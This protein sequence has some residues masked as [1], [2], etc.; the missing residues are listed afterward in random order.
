MGGI[1]TPFRKALLA[2]TKSFSTADPAPIQFATAAETRSSFARGQIAIVGYS[3]GFWA[4]DPV[5]DLQMF[6]TPGLHPELNFITSDRPLQ[7]MLG[8]LDGVS[9]EQ[10][11]ERLKS[12]NRYL[13]EGALASVVSHARLF[14]LARDPAIL[15][16]PIFALSSPAPWQIFNYR[17]NL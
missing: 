7:A 5:G 12:I 9:N 1:D 4:Q 10:M 6:F 11:G 14:F 8:D 17:T 3:S 2:A 15:A 13:F 16:E